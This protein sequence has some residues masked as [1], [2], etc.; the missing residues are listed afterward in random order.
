MIIRTEIPETQP[1]VSMQQH[2]SVSASGR[3][4]R[5]NTGRNVQ[6][7]NEARAAI[8]QNLGAEKWFQHVLFISRKSCIIQKVTDEDDRAGETVRRQPF[9]EL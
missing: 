2:R 9:S 5:H 1:C 7:R 6:P 4:V 3:L 8:D